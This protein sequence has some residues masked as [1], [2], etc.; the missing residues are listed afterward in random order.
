MS[1]SVLNSFTTKHS[2]SQ[3]EGTSWDLPRKGP[4]SLCTMSQQP[5]PPPLYVWP[6]FLGF[7]KAV[8]LC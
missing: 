1:M 7:L 3:G 5:S 2:L 8:I 6:T 4:G